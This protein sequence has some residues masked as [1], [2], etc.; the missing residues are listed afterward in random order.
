M[1]TQLPVREQYPCGPQVV[2]L[3]CV[4]HATPNQPAWQTH[5]PLLLAG[6]LCRPQNVLQSEP[7]QPAWQLRQVHPARLPDAVPRP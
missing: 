6:V 7:C 1:H 3:H 4:A 2:L 5:A